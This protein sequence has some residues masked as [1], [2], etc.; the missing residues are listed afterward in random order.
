MEQAFRKAPVVTG[1]RGNKEKKGQVVRCPRRRVVAP[2]ATA[3]RP[4]KAILADIAMK[5]IN[6]SVLK[7]F[8]STRI[9]RNNQQQS[10]SPR[11]LRAVYKVA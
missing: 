7:L 2:E 8:L 6:A 3:T 11:D 1:M 5:V 4:A 9:P 10:H